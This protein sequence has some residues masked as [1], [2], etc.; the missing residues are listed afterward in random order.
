MAFQKW[1]RLTNL[2]QLIVP[3]PKQELLER[4]PA[5][6]KNS[7]ARDFYLADCAFHS[8]DWRRL[9]AVAKNIGTV[10]RPT[11]GLWEWT[12]IFRTQTS[13]R[14]CKRSLGSWHA[15]GQDTMEKESRSKIA[16]SVA[17]MAVGQT[18]TLACND[19]PTKINGSNKLLPRL[20]IMLNGYGKEDPATIKN[21]Q[22]KQTSRS[23]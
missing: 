15:S 18:I 11:Q 7:Y 17:L 14:E 20:Q 9:P 2:F 16:Q 21:Y 13:Q 22:S 4:V 3:A 8:D 10:G 19:N 6:L 1:T 23:S 12:H 5:H